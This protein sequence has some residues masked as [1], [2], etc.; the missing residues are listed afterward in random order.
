MKLHFN[1][2]GEGQP[3]VLTH[4][5]FGSGDNLVTVSKAIAEKG[6]RVYLV[7]ARNHGRSDHTPEMTYSLMAADFHEFL[8]NQKLVN[9]VIAGHSMGGKMVLQYSQN[10]DNYSKMVVI[11]IAPRH[12]TPHH[13]HILNGLRAIDLKVVKTR[14]E[15]EDV[16]S[17]FVSDPG[18]RQFI[19]KNIYRSDAGFAWRI[20]VEAIAQNIENIGAKIELKR[21]VNKPALFIAG[22]ESNYVGEDD[23]KLIRTFYENSYIVHI[24]GANHWVHASKPKEFVETFTKFLSL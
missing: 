6:Y 22:A 9:P 23:E 2:I 5:V 12:Y 4:G 7:D 19:L 20:N 3:I 1:T 13:D 11:D 24:K 8:N 21:K 18:E 16:F 10:Y 17:K 14:R 15:A